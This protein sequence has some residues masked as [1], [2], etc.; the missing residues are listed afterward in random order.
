MGEFESIPRFNFEVGKS[1]VSRSASKFILIN[2]FA[3][4]AI[5]GKKESATGRERE[6]E[7]RDPKSDPLENYAKVPIIISVPFCSLSIRPRRRIFPFAFIRYSATRISNFGSAVSPYAALF[8][9]DMQL[10]RDMKR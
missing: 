6:R 9:R 10:R 8:A 4:D 1:T 2:A 3:N 5:K 7:R